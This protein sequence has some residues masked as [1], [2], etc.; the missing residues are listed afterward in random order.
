MRWLHQNV[1]ILYVS[2]VT[3]M[4]LFGARNVVILIEGNVLHE[5]VTAAA[6]FSK[7]NQPRRA[8]IAS[9]PWLKCCKTIMDFWRPMT[10]S[11]VRPKCGEDIMKCVTQSG[12]V[13]NITEMSLNYLPKAPFQ[14][15]YM[16]KTSLNQHLDHDAPRRHARYGTMTEMSFN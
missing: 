11:T 13:H 10:T 14:W 1:F 16:I 4:C 3:Q 6:M 12:Y 2:H 15:A 9:K 5:C 8:V 7:H